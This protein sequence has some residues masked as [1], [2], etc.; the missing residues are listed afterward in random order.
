MGMLQSAGT[1]WTYV[2]GD[3]AASWT[4]DSEDT[5]IFYST[6]SDLQDI[7]IDDLSVREVLTGR[8]LPV[9]RGSYRREVE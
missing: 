7:H 4:G 1:H 9:V 3:F 8:S 2:S 6:Y 5:V